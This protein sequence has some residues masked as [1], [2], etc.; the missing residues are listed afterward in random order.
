M[1]KG[2][3]RIFEQVDASRAA[4]FVGGLGV[5]WAWIHAT[6]TAPVFAS[7]DSGYG[8]F[9]LSNGCLLMTLAFIGLFGERLKL[10]THVP[11][12]A[13]VCGG[14]ACVGTVLLGAAFLVGDFEDALRFAGTIV[15]AV[16]T[17]GLIALWGEGFVQFGDTAALKY[18]ALL[19]VLASFFLFLL[20]GTFSGWASLAV[21]SLLP[22]VSIWSLCAIFRR[23]PGSSEGPE[24]DGER[25]AVKR[26][27]VYGS[28]VN[29][30]REGAFRRLLVYIFAFSV[31]LNFLNM[32][33][34]DNRGVGSPADWMLVFASLLLVTVA[35]VVVE[36][37]AGRRKVSTL[38]VLI[39]VLATGALMAYLFADVSNPTVLYICMYAG[40]YLFLAS[41]FFYLGAYAQRSRYPAYLVFVWGNA[42]NSLGLI[43]GSGIGYLVGRFLD[44]W[45]TVVTIA[46]VYAVFLV[47]FLVLP[48]ARSE[49]FVSVPIGGDGATTTTGSDA[50]AQG[51][52][53]ESI[54]VRAHL[55]ADAYRLST[56]EE[57]VLAY[58]LRG[59]SLASIAEEL[60]V[61][62]NTV[63]T[64][65]NH[66]Y[67][68]LD[69]HTREELMK[70]TEEL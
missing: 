61:S 14:L 63:K 23:R 22:L 56:R 53:V 54:F 31:P 32:R 69:V 49:S 68:K 12:L 36:M 15:T 42:A 59:R 33:I 18:L 70:L 45:S 48:E 20:V 62:Q 51:G 9:A 3:H 37:L 11:Q 8:I 7:P 55:A 28:V 40:Y 39:A 4:L 21:V 29:I 47:G 41:F 27:A 67:K 2:F 46:I 25:F 66:I 50:A 35:I 6:V 19:S 34:A 43:A 58:L 52:I 13:L 26:S 65:V 30:V 17:G 64:H 10:R 38:P 57:E 16:A 1:A 44:P 24:D 60:Y 5:F